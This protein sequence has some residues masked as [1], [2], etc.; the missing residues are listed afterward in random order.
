MDWRAVLAALC[1]F[2]FTYALIFSERV[3]R[4]IAALAGAVAMMIAGAWLGFLP[5]EQ[6]MALVDFDTIWLL[7]G[8]MILVGMLRETGFFQYVAV[9]AARLA[10]GNPRVLLVSLTLVAAFMSM[11][12]DNL[13]TV[14]AMVPITLSIAEVLGVSPLPYLLGQVLMAN[15]GGAATLVGDPPNIIIGSSAH[16]SFNDFLAHAAPAAL[17]VMAATLVF[18]LFR[19]RRPLAARPERV[20]HIM[21][22][23]PSRALADRR[24]VVK[25][26][27]IVGL[28][29][30][31]FLVHGALG[32]S[33]GLVALIGAVLAAFVLRPTAGAFL[34]GV[35]WEMILFLI[36]LF[37]V[38]GG[39][40]RTGVF[41]AAAEGLVHLG[42]SPLLLAL[43]V[44]W[45][46]AVLCW[47][48]GA[49]PATVVMVPVVRG[50]VA[51]G[52][53]GDVLWWALVLGVG[54]GANGT[55]IATA[56][57]IALVGLSERGAEEIH[58]RTWLVTGMPASLLGCVL[59][60]LVL[61]FALATGWMA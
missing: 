44:L 60:S 33:P 26:L 45:V 54:F 28:V 49:V 14:L 39:V 30:C 41:A 61:W 46:G 57:N 8:M 51:L 21:S 11:I 42:G 6:A 1:V 29:V 52:G 10:R 36:G 53:A 15:V 16:F 4:M 37:V 40:D 55:P 19:Y 17:L 12:L 34:A 56:A 7:V 5:S 32:L 9:W 35:E 47:A 48:I 50:L 58:T 13:T 22:M 3:P 31:M 43:V 27:G 25:L 23:D 59:G 38:V 20:E 2:A 18:L 24:G